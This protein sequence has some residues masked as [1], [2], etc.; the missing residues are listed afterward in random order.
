V[1]WL[2]AYVLGIKTCNGEKLCISP[3]FSKQFE[4][5]KGSYAFK[6]GTVEVYW[7]CEQ[8][9]VVLEVTRKGDFEIEF[10]FG[11]RKVLSEEKAND[12]QVFT[13]TI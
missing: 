12:K 11:G 10:D 8:D 2:Y 7:H 9:G 5:A 4:Y 1:Y 6:N 3:D 13:L